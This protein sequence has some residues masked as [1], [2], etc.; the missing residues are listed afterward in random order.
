MAKFN[1]KTIAVDAKSG[2]RCG[3]F[4]TPHG[5]IETPI[6]MP[7]GTAATVKS[8]LPSVLNEI[9]TQILLSNTYHLYLRPGN[10]IVREAGGL[11]KFMHWDKP[12]LT[13]SGGF[14]VFSLGKLRK[15]TD[16]GVVFS[17]HIDG[18]KHKFTPE[19]VME[20]EHDLGA[21][22]I[23]AFDECSNYGVDHNYAEKAMYRTLRWL[24]RCVHNHTND[25]QMLF[26][27]IQ[28]N[29]FEDLRVESVK[30]TV[31]FAECGIAVGGLSV[32]EPSD[33]M[34]RMMDVM[35]PYYPDNMPRYLMGVGTPDYILE[36]ISRGIDMFD[37]VLPTRIARNGTAM[38][39]HGKVVVRNGV[40]KRDFSP[41]DDNCDCYCCKHFTKA[42]L[43]H[44]INCNEILGAEL[45]SM[46]NIRFLLKL[47]E[48][49]REAIKN[50][51][52][53]D[54]KS[55]FYQ[56]YYGSPNIACK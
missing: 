38:T 41:L 4:T 28:G 54:F 12:I 5:Q 46:H 52:F 49:A 51:R 10:E 25:T 45:L 56:N 23:M 2:A 17:S 16:E 39:S 33:V 35:R 48:N 43:R 30:R 3:I 34:Y 14:Q 22:I 26:P 29:M 47:V 20:I 6:Y 31:Q 21:D 40:Y 19:S 27:I 42:Y 11:H 37:C 9:G 50:N 32:G 53:D 36:G 18:S 44:L 24:E 1:F 13:D 55:E 8:L 15:I 7:V